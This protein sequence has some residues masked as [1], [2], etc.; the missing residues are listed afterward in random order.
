[1]LSEK[2]L[3]LF[4]CFFYWGPPPPLS[5]PLQPGQEIWMQLKKKK[6]KKKKKKPDRKINL[7]SSPP[8]PKFTF[9][10]PPTLTPLTTLQLLPKKTPNNLR[11]ASGRSNPLRPQSSGAARGARSTSP[12]PQLLQGWNQDRPAPR[13]PLC[14]SRLSRSMHRRR[15]W[16]QSACCGEIDPRR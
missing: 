9:S 11:T 8:P 3:A 5:P 15:V 16:T 10:L 13:V 7:N 6:K 2:R 4:G 1:M 14:S 12:P